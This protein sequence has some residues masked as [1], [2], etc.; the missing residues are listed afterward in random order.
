M[1]FPECIR[2]WGFKFWELLQA[3]WHSWES[4]NLLL[5]TLPLSK[6]P[7]CSNPWKVQGTPKRH[8][9]FVCKI[10]DE[11]ELPHLCAQLILVQMRWRNSTEVKIKSPIYKRPHMQ[12]TVLSHAS[13]LHL[14]SYRWRLV[15]WNTARS[16][17]SVLCEHKH[18]PPLHL[19]ISI[20]TSGFL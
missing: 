14:H 1:V 16:P 10:M 9:R 19:H 18:P 2:R 17:H 13:V 6:I 11:S 3:S 7:S 8:L 5:P 4:C 12:S 15:H 20:K